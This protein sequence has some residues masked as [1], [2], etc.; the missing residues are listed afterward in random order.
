[1]AVHCQGMLQPD[2]PPCHCLA[3]D[4]G[5]AEQAVKSYDTS[6]RLL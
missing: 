4:L 2:Q 5:R 3:S 6:V 1:M